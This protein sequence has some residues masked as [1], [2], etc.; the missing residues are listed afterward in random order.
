MLTRYASFFSVQARNA[1]RENARLRRDM[2]KA[3]NDF[4][5]AKR[6]ADGL[7]RDKSDAETK[8]GRAEAAV[9]ALKQD[10]GALEL[11]CGEAELERDTAKDATAHGT[12]LWIAYAR[13]PSTETQVSGVRF[14]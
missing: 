11:R 13:V 7:K 4:I 6:E 14:C 12:C 9:A 8:V 2:T 10:F 5:D 1:L 3:T